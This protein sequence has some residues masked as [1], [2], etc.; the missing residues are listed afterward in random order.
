MQN[1]ASDPATGQIAANETDRLIASNKVEGTAIYHRQ[2]ER[3]GSIYYFMVAQ[4]SGQAV[5]NSI[6]CTKAC[7]AQWCKA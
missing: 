3:R 7:L 5:M 4:R 1:V 2:G 6:G